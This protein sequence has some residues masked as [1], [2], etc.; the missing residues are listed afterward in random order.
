MTPDEIRAYALDAA[1][2]MGAAWRM[3]SA[4]DI[5]ALAK[6]FARYIAGDPVHPP[7]SAPAPGVSASPPN[8]TVES[9]WGPPCPGCTHSAGVHL[10]SGCQADE[11]RC[12]WNEREARAASTECQCGECTHSLRVHDGSG[13]I[14]NGCGCTRTRT[15]R[16]TPP[17][18]PA[19][20]VKCQC[21][22][23]H[24]E[25]QGRRQFCAAWLNTGNICPCEEYTP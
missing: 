21:G 3:E 8:E 4:P 12:T 7:T 25:H 19:P 20:V 1:S 15:T 17:S 10:H 2:R 23:P 6:V 11:C 22:H 14:L 24:S 18:A 13:C 9:V 16:I 5:V